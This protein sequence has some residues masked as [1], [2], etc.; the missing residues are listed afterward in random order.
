MAVGDSTPYSAADARVDGPPNFED[1]IPEDQ[2][3]PPPTYTQVRNANRPEI[4]VLIPERRPSFSEGPRQLGSPISIISPLDNATSMSQSLTSCNLT[5]LEDIRHEDAGHSIGM[6]ARVSTVPHYPVLLDPPTQ[7]ASRNTRRLS[8]RPVSTSPSTTGLYMSFGQLPGAEPFEPQPMLSPTERR[9]QLRRS[10]TV[11]QSNQAPTYISVSSVGSTPVNADITT[12]S[13]SVISAPISP[14]ETSTNHSREPSDMSFVRHDDPPN[15]DLRHPD[16]R[17]WLW[18]P[19]AQGYYA[20]PPPAP[21]QRTWP[22]DPLN[23]HWYESWNNSSIQRDIQRASWDNR[24]SQRRSS[25]DAEDNPPPVPPKDPGYVPRPPNIVYAYRLRTCHSSPLLRIGGDTG[26]Y[27]SGDAPT[28]A[29][30][31]CHQRSTATENPV[32]PSGGAGSPFRTSGAVVPWTHENPMSPR[33]WDTGENIHGYGGGETT[34]G[35]N[36]CGDPRK[37]VG[38][39]Y[40]DNIRPQFTSPSSS[41]SPWQP[42]NRA[43]A[44]L[45]ACVRLISRSIPRGGSGRVQVH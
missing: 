8:R 34:G 37:H 33:R 21:R 5:S 44:V 6:D 40:H 42:A 4:A 39:V 36:N 10:Q 26:P 30:T 32:V 1:P 18:K 27:V 13:G 19:P 35:R 12:V 23:E 2:P 22:S 38:G 20:P 9:Q 28:T 29:V 45:D 7:L 3:L 14:Y 31:G 11:P 15:L 43:S 16:R 17:R 25:R 24:R 41:S